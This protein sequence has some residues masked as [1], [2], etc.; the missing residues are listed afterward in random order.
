MVHGPCATLA[1]CSQSRKG[2]GWRV[3]SWIVYR[4]QIARSR[5]ALIAYRVSDRVLSRL[6]P[7]RALDR[8]QI[9]QP[10]GAAKTGQYVL[11]PQP[12]TLGV[13]NQR[14][15]IEQGSNGSGHERVAETH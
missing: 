10:L 8:V 15:T 11:L 3:A 14:V 4:V 7:D 9:A 5:I 2:P 1:C 13:Q 6:T 12:S